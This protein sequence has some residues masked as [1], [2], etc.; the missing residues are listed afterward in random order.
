MGENS[1]ATKNLEAAYDVV[2]ILGSLIE[3]MG[4][5]HN[6]LWPCF[7]CHVTCK[8]KFVMGELPFLTF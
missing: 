5:P 1:S 6:P 3:K 8:L 2:S 7:A 4:W